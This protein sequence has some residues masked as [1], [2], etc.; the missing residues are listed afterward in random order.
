MNIEISQGNIESINADTIIVNLFT[1]VQNPAGATGAVD[2]ALDGA[3]TD[4]IKNGDLIGQSGEITILYPRGTINAVRVLVVGLGKREDFD[5]ESVRRASALAITRARQLKAK[6]V[7]TIVHGSGIGGLPVTDAAQA[8]VEGALLA[9]Y[10]YNA[11]KQQIGAAHEV[12][13]LVLVEYDEGKITEIEQGLQTALAISAGVQIARELVNMPPN[14]ATPT[15][16]AAEAKELSKE[17]D[18]DIT[19]GG[20][21]W[22]KKRGMGAFL[23]VAQGAGERPEICCF[24]TQ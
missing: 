17:H 18:L 22:A 19:I 20:R 1:D 7:A 5:L 4:L 10:R 16:I 6:K 8:T 21:R 3:I 9:L 12:E 13:S 15:R 23:A 11:P 24:R 14:V 2:Q